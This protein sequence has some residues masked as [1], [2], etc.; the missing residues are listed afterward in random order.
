MRELEHA[1]AKIAFE[2]AH[3]S[4]LKGSGSAKKKFSC[5]REAAGDFLG[6]DILLA[7]V[8]IAAPNT[9]RNL[10]LLKAALLEVYRFVHPVP[11]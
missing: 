11:G 3:R 4:F 2:P 7:L 5:F 10:W 9:L 1:F 6:S 8:V